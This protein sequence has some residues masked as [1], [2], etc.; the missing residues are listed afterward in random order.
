MDRKGKGKESE[1]IKVRAIIFLNRPGQNEKNP[2]TSEEAV[3]YVFNSHQSELITYYPAEFKLPG[4]TDTFR[5][6]A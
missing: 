3:Q 1:R 6:S 4:K 2:R 5:I